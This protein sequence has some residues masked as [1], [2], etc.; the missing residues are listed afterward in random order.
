MVFMGS[1]PFLTHTIHTRKKRKR[2]KR[3]EP[4][5]LR[6]RG[7]KNR[8]P[9]AEGVCG[10]MLCVCGSLSSHAP[11]IKKHQIALQK[12]FQNPKKG[13][14]LC[15]LRRVKK[16]QKATLLTGGIQENPK[17]RAKWRPKLYIIRKRGRNGQ[18]RGMS[19]VL[20]AEEHRESRLHGRRSYL[21][22]DKVQ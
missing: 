8:E 11:T 21:A 12:I 10:G 19:E 7:E 9:Q 18:I 15:K 16:P 1:V 22:C 6:E 20:R 3:S 4:P 2:K 17:K 13:N 5:P 14:I